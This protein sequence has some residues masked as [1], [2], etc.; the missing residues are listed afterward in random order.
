MTRNTLLK[1][2]GLAVFLLVLTSVVL[3]WS[4]PQ[5]SGQQTAY[6]PMG[7]VTRIEVT[8]NV[9]TPLKRIRDKK[10]VDAIVGFIDKHA[11]GWSSPWAGVP[12]PKI[13]VNLYDGQEFKGH[14]GAGNGFFET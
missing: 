12:V 10:Q 14:F 2:T 13:V 5:L 7:G 6:A 3:V 8:D 9:S 1:I 4:V 11:S